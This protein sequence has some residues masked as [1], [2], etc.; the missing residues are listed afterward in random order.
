[1]SVRRRRV[2]RWARLGILVQVVFTVAL[3]LVALLLVN[4]LVGRPGWR[5][6]ID[7]TEK[8]LNTLSTA[9]LGVLSRLEEPVTIDVFFRGEEGPLVRV[10]ADVMQRTYRLLVLMASEGGEKIDLH[11]N[12]TAD[13][14]AIETRRN[15]LRLRGFEN[16]LVVSQGDRR[17]VLRLRGD[18]AEL[19]P[20]RPHELGGFVPASIVAFKAEEAIVQG[21]L[22]LTR[23]ERPH[24]YFTTGQG[25]RDLYGLEEWSDLGQLQNALLED[26]F[27]VARWNFEQD[28][29]LP[30]DCAALAVIGPE[31]PFSEEMFDVVTNYIDT[32]GRLIAAPHNNPERFDASSLG[33]LLERYGIGMSRG[34]VLRPY[35]DAAGQR[36]V[37]FE[38]NL[39]VRVGPA[40]MTRHPI[41]DPLREGG[42]SV[43]LTFA[44]EVSV[45]PGGQPARGATLPLLRSV[46]DAWLDVPPIDFLPDATA[47]ETRAFDLGVISAFVPEGAEAAE[48]LGVQ[49]QSRIVALGSADAFCNKAIE[50]NADFLRNVF[51]WAVSRDYRVSISPRDPDLRRLPIGETDALANLTR[52]CLWGLPGVC[53]LLGVVTAVMRARGGRPRTA[54]AKS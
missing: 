39:V 3:A 23:G 47:E 40:Q 14:L 30:E 51:N 42:R 28:G 9:T 49:T 44:R 8:K 34:L 22:K 38:G 33:E 25:E 16:C 15:E 43:V 26:G 11:F 6:R 4:W 12:D 27:E 1:M 36:T 7:L 21:I 10:G 32:G 20:G 35:V 52:F 37:G 45:L 54:R 13:P 17:E 19:D 41:M 5:Q 24:V 29:P 18:L 46:A 50:V 53:L 31:A 48:A 2:G